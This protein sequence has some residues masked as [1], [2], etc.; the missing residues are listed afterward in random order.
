MGGHRRTLD[1]LRCIW[2]ENQDLRLMLSESGLIF[3]QQEGD[4]STLDW[5]HK[6]LSIAPTVY[7]IHYK[8][9]R[10]CLRGNIGCAWM[11]KLVIEIA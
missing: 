10:K 2:D 5:A 1:I 8:I 7:L 6:T 4:L 9:D 11:L 3:R